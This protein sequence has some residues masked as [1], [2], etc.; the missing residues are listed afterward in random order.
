M[1]LFHSAKVFY[2][3][4]QYPRHG[5]H[6]P[7]DRDGHAVAYLRYKLTSIIAAAILLY[8]KN[9]EALIIFKAYICHDH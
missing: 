3:L 8:Q 1:A 7:A 6:G 9:T 5:P 4:V 2:G